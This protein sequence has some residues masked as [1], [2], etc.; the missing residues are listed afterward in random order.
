MDGFIAWAPEVAISDDGFEP[1]FY[2]ILYE[3]ENK[4]FWFRGRNDFIVWA[5]RKYASR[6]DKFLEVGC[7]TGIVLSEIERFF[8]SANL[9]GGEIYVEGLKH[10]SQRTLN[11]NLSQMDARYVPYVDEFD[12]IGA[13]DVIEHIDQDIDVLKSMHRAIMDSGIIILTVP[14]H[15]WLWSDIDKIACH[16]R[17]YTKREL[18]YKLEL[19]GFEILR[20]TSFVSALLPAMATLR[21]FAGKTGDS[22]STKLCAGL[23]VYSWVNSMLYWLLRLEKCLVTLGLNLPFGGSRL[24]V[25]RKTQK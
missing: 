18:H 20:S 19:A 23:N 25:A 6:L 12:V 21:L 2:K 4:N 1:S 10:A 13:F 8:P 5:L 14:Q 22:T 11:V 24:V 17:R 16:K 15:K 7:G 3:V 9:F